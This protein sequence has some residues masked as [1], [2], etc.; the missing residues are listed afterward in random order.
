MNMKW[1]AAISER[2]DGVVF[3]MAGMLGGGLL[4]T[5][6]IRPHVLSYFCY[7]L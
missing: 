7:L 6:R 5:W 4:I 1:V 3:K 2:R